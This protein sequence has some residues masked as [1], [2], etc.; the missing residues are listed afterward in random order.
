MK[1]ITALLLMFI[2][3]M[4]TLPVM[5][6]VQ[7]EIWVSSPG[8][9][10][11]ITS[12]EIMFN[13]AVASGAA[14][15][16]KLD[17]VGDRYYLGVVEDKHT[18]GGS[19]G[20]KKT[21]YLDY[22]SIF[23]TDDGF[24]ILGRVGVGNEYYWNGMEGVLDVS[25]N[26]DTEFYIS[27][28]YEAP[29]YI[30]NPHDKYT[31]SGWDEYND[32]IFIGSN[33]GIAK[34]SDWKDYGQA[35]FPMIY[36]NKVCTGQN[37]YYSSGNS[38]YYYLSDGKTR[39]TQIR[40][41][42]IK[43]GEI[44]NV[45]SL[46]SVA[47]TSVTD[48]NG[49]KVYNDGMSGNTLVESYYSIPDNSGRFFNYKY[50]YNSSTG[51]YTCVLK[52]YKNISGK[53]TEVQT[54]T[55][56][57]NLA[58]VSNIYPYSISGIDESVYSTKGIS[59]PVVRLGD[60]YVLKNG[61]MLR[62]TPDST[63]NEYELCVYNNRLATIRTVANASYIYYPDETGYKQ[64]WQRINYLDFTSS[65]II[66]GEDMDMLVGLSTNLDGY[67]SNYYTF[68]QGNKVSS[69]N[70]A[71]LKEWWPHTLN[72]KFSDG[73]YVAGRWVGMGNSMYEIWYD[74]YDKDGQLIST[75]ASDF[76]TVASS[77]LYTKEL[78]SNE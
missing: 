28:G 66:P 55:C 49:F 42:G 59:A 25:K 78:V 10:C 43:N 62:F 2:L 53:M 46:A 24:I 30:I 51:K 13:K 38:Y 20:K 72:N 44:I 4:G 37:M 50:E 12:N 56:E 63:Y 48:A 32:Y 9:T 26:I 40:V 14:R 58:T 34:I 68:N 54:E 70:G 6:E 74:I 22:F 1:K 3:L 35:R 19:N 61:K 11:G 65:G 69:L 77:S 76:S 23:E 18:D 71:T 29:Y 64:Y 67:Y 5:A 31:Y 21:S 7:R 73:R 39:A 60:L 27:R 45:T 75:G 8:I 47:A 33:G 41:I 57:T 52:I 16:Y 36:E 17:S 15:L